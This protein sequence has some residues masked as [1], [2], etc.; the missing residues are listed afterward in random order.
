[1]GVG[2][3]NFTTQQC[4]RALTQLGFLLGNRRGKHDK[5][6]PPKTIADKLAGTQPRF[7]MVPRHRDLH[8]QHEI[9]SEIRKMGGTDLVERF[10]NFL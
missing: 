9:V 2:E 3:W 1:L 10:K 5:Y 4:I 8:C 7:I 6:F